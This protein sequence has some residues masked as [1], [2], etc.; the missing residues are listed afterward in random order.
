MVIAYS[1]DRKT[2]ATV[3]SNREDAALTKANPVELKLAA[4]IEHTIMVTKDGQSVS[5][6][7]VWS[8]TSDYP[9]TIAEARTD[10]N[11]VA[12]L[13]FS[14]NAKPAK[15][16]CWHETMGVCALDVPS[17]S[18]GSSETFEMKLLPTRTCKALVLDENEKP[19][20]IVFGTGVSS[21]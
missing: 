17:E 3:S 14:A 4:A 15:T 20:P 21:Q 12:K 8:H 1:P 11:G 13:L 5:D 6:A 7:L 9:F 2:I 16:L 10:G 18:W 19:V